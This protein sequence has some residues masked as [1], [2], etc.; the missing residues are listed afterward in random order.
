[1]IYPYGWANLPAILTAA[2]DAVDLQG[3][4]TPRLVKFS[5]LM[6]VHTMERRDLSAVISLAPCYHH[7]VKDL[8]A[9]LKA[10][11]L[12]DLPATVYG[13][14]GDF[15][16]QVKDLAAVIS[17]EPLTGLP[18][19]T[20]VIDIFFGPTVDVYAFDDLPVTYWGKIQHPTD[21]IAVEYIPGGG[22]RIQ[23]LLNAY[24]NPTPMYSDMQASIE[25]VIQLP[26]E[27]RRGRVDARILKDKY[28]D[29]YEDLATFKAPYIQN[30]MELFSRTVQIRFLEGVADYFYQSSANVVWKVDSEEKWVID[31]KSWLEEE[32]FIADK[33]EEKTKIVSDITQFESVDE[34]IRYAIDWVL[35]F[36]QRDLPA[37]ITGA[38][39]EIT[40][41]K[42]LT[43]TITGGGKIYSS[44][45]NLPAQTQPWVPSNLPASLQLYGNG[46]AWAGH[47]LRDL[48]ARVG[49]WWQ[50]PDLGATIQCV[51]WKNAHIEMGGAYA[52]PDFDDVDVEL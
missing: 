20:D 45:L 44:Y 50:A 8:G 30:N 17:T 16:A 26:Y 49:Y 23:R 18:R 32:E 42:D 13:F 2:G 21:E 22:R 37:I 40:K 28:F 33:K 3:I 5:M 46:P 14:R 43:A 25:G 35:A 7:E 6:P 9:Y 47:E 31:V 52:A 34:A 36:P 29:A 10:L 48:P 24:V 51:D 39:H 19:A 15:W 27:F 4:I 41:L 1:V 38:R 11:Y 12:K